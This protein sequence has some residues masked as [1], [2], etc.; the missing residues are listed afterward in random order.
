M[1]TV[2]VVVVGLALSM[3]AFAVTISNAFVYGHEGRRLLLLMPLLFGFFQAG[4]PVLGYLLGGLAARFIEAYAGVVSLVI[5]GAIGVGM[6]REGISSLRA[7]EETVGEGPVSGAS[8]CPS[9]PCRRWP[10]PLTHSPLG[11]RCVPPRSTCPLPS[12]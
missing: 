10:R 9:L 5:L 12:A 8:R 7:G 1:G 3:D 11:S 2:E 4:M 6:L